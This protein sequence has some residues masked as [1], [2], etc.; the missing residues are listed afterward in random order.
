M[1]LLLGTTCA[2]LLL[3]CGGGAKKTADPE[4][5]DGSACSETADHVTDVLVAGEQLPAGKRDVVVRV[6]TERCL[7]DQWATEVVSCLRGA[8]DFELFEGCTKQ[9]TEAQHQAVL[10]QL[11]REAPMPHH[12]EEPASAPSGGGGGGGT[13]APPP[14]PDDPCGGG[15]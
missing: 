3:A 1:K 9:L 4:L 10:E 13:G 7:A 6:I 2:A 11:E 5:K 12:H 8:T 15:A 14:P